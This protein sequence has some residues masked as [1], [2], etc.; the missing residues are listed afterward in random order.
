MPLPQQVD[1]IINAKWILPIVPRG[2]VFE[3]CSLVV[4]QGRI[5][6]IHPTA[7]LGQVYN[8]LNTL[9]LSHHVLMPGLINTHGHA[10]M[11][12]L[13]GYADDKPLM[14]WLQQHIWPAE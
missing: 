10:A 11:S 6:A 1:T 3:D 12:L 5:V 7:E 2:R 8:S 14:D 4:H 13:R 9:D